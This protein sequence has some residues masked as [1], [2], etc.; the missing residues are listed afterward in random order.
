M[1]LARLALPTLFLVACVGEPGP[2]PPTFDPCAP[3]VLTAADD[4]SAAERESLDDA[5]ALW[6]AMLGAKVT[7][8][9][10]AGAPR[11]LVA[12][13]DAPLAF[14]GIY[15]PAGIAVNRGLTDPSA[16]AVVLAHELGHVFGLS[17][18]DDTASVMRPGNLSV[19]PGA[20]DAAA[21]AAIWGECP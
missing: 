6:R 17:H 14:L 16:R 21:L 18:V 12:F 10:V 2:E 19:P 5:V 13:R 3:L 15:E 8:I 9:D 20:R 4:A 11:M 7:T 1:R